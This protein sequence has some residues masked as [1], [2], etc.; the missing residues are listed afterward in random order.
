MLPQRVS[1]LP[2]P[3]DANSSVLS[4]VPES[5]TIR[6]ITVKL[7]FILL[8]FWMRNSTKLLHVVL[9]SPE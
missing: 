6:Y 1:L 4:T 7:R 2:T 8:C 9:Y 5:H 3:N